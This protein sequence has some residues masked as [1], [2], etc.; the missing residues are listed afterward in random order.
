MKRGGKRGWEKPPPWPAKRVATF[1]QHRTCPRGT[2][3]YHWDSLCHIHLLLFEL[4]ALSIS[5]L[6]AASLRRSVPPL[7]CR[8]CVVRLGLLPFFVQLHASVQVAFPG[9]SALRG[10][11]IAADPRLL[12]VAHLRAMRSG[13]AIVS[14][15]SRVSSIGLFRPPSL[16]RNVKVADDVQSPSDHLVER[17]ARLNKEQGFKQRI[18]G[19]SSWN[20]GNDKGESGKR[21]ENGA[22]RRASM[23]ARA[24]EASTV[25]MELLKVTG[26]HNQTPHTLKIIITSESGNIPQTP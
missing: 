5:L 12:D 20:S 9:F 14:P 10:S 11:P 1:D 8:A 13:S 21:K 22:Q 24:K 4:C 17:P 25:L 2:R 26:G 7:L 6:F 19:E 15:P 23:E 16:H 3:S 18:Q